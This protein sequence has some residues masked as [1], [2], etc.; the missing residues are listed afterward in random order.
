[1]TKKTRQEKIIADLRRKLKQTSEQQS[2]SV[3]SSSLRHPEEKTKV[4]LSFKTVNKPNPLSYAPKTMAYDYTYVAK[5]LKRIII[6]T[7]LAFG[8]EFFLYFILPK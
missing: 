3:T 4:S 6:L 8:W 2:P 5:D 1:M 7:V